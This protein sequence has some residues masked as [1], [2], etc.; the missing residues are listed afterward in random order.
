[1]V[2]DE[3]RRLATFGHHIDVSSYD[4]ESLIREGYHRLHGARP[5]RAAVER[6]LQELVAGNLLRSASINSHLA[7]LTLAESKKV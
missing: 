2:A 3:C 6:Y 4:L 5:M 1:M 7:N